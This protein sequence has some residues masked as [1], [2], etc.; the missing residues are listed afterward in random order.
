MT[1]LGNGIHLSTVAE[2]GW[3]PDLDIGGQADLV[4]D[5]EGTTAGL[6]RADPDIGGSPADPVT[7]PA[8]ET[9]Y[10]IAGR[11]RI[12]IGTTDV[13]DLG[14]GD[15]I[16]LPAGAAVGWDPT[17]DCQVFWVYS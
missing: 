12:P 11:V 15:M 17:D 14:P 3:Q 6:W 9:I 2:R 8:R 13:F 5:A 16:S 7:I 1:D 4:V 10:V